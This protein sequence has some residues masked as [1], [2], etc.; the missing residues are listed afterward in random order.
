[1]K[2]PILSTAFAALTV[3]AAGLMVPSP[4]S[5]GDDCDVSRDQWQ[6]ETALRQ[7]LEGQ[8]W[9]IRRIKVDDGCYEV[10]ATDK[11]GRRKEVYFDPRTLQ[12]TGEDD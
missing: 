9:Q 6:P 11:A 3:A 8:G 10:Y 7:Q 5:A 4:A 12:P 1:M 2:Y